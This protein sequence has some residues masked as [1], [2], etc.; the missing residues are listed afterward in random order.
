MILQFTTKRELM[1]GFAK[2][3]NLVS[4]E[5]QNHHE[6]VAY[7]SYHLADVMGMS[8]EQKQMALFGG[9]LHDIGGFMGK[10]KVSLMELEQNARAMSKVGASL[11]SLVPSVNP[12]AGIVRESQTPWEMLKTTFGKLSAPQQIG[13]IVHLADVT[14]LL[15]ADTDTVLNQTA[16]VKECIHKIGTKEFSPAVLEAFDRICQLEIVWLNTAYHP[17]Q[18]LD[19]INDD[20][21]L[22]LEETSRLTELM[23]KIID[24]RSPFTAMHSAGVAA[25]AVALAEKFDMADDECRMMQIAGNLH[26]IG[27]M[28]VPNEI[29]EKP[30]KLTEHEFNIM[31][32]HA[33]YTWILLKDI[34]GFEVITQWAAFHHEKLDASGYPFHFPG[35]ELSLGSRIMTVADIFSALTEDRPYRKSMEREQVIRILREDAGRGLLSEGVVEMLIDHYDEINER[36]DTESRAASRTYQK[37]LAEAREQEKEKSN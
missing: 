27:K 22:S 32:E 3:M 13:Q 6:K 31:K 11:L 34:K 2:A 35:R 26:D 12:F 36:R 4:P 30:G 37:S 7:F 15:L 28:R 5:V 14:S 18:F 17:E 21:W 23:S 20:R 25:S 8:A 29:L 19:L 16:S 24:F 9:L 33:Y 1:K 10:E